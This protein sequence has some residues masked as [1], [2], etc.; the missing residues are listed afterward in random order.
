MLSGVLIKAL[1]IYVLIRIFF[2][3]LGAP[4][5][6]LQAFLILGAV[7]LLLGVFLAVGQWDLKRLLAYHSISQVG[8]IL[9]GIGLNT[10]LGMAGAVFHLLNHALFKALLFYNAG[11]LE[12]GLGTRDLEG[13][14]SPAHAITAPPRWSPAGI[15]RI[16][17]SGFFSKLRIILRIRTAG[18][19]LVVVGSLLTSIAESPALRHRR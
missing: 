15:S 3:V 17:F 12:M 16:P 11:S 10:S 1:G 14:T 13:E 18:L 4:R 2:N 5:V 19:Y 8:Y 9:L 7:S 6:F